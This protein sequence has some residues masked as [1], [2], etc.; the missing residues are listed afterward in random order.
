MQQPWPPESRK[1]FWGVLPGKNFS[2]F[3][4]LK[5]NLIGG[6]RLA[7][8]S[9]IFFSKIFARLLSKSPVAGFIPY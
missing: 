6:V 9:G 3:L 8:I 7:Q 5:L 4:F 1:G 2:N